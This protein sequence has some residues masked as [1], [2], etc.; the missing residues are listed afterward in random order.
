M[1]NQKSKKKYCPDCGGSQVNHRM[2]Y[3]SVFLGTMIEPWTNWMGKILPER[4]IEW[5]GPLVIK[6]LAF[7]RLGRITTK[8][9]KDDSGRTEVLWTEAIARGIDMR[10]FRLF[11][12]GHDIF[13]SKYKGQMRFFDVL[14]R[15][16]DYNPEGLGWMDNKNEM[17]KHFRKAGDIPVARGDIASTLSKGLKIFRSLDKP[18][19]TKPNIGSRSRHTTTHIGTEEEFRAAFKKAQQLSPWVMIEEELSGFVF[20]GTLI[21]KKLE[22][23]LRREP[24]YVEGDGI[25]AVRELIDRENENPLRQ[26]PIFHTLSLD[27]EAEKE[28]SHW[29]RTPDTVPRKGEAVTLGQ[30]TSRAV[31]GGIT[32]VTDMIHPDNRAMLERI[33][34][35]LDDPLI[36]VDFI[37][38]DIS[39]SWRDQPRSGVIECNSAPFIDLHHYPLVGKPRNIAARLWDIIYPESAV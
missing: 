23:V 4:S 24:A 3:T 8:P 37:M 34:D 39:V 1:Q 36:G 26:G 25:H 12:I 14:P 17:K 20:R 19:I 6:T 16:A 31:G 35:V 30:K 11:G 2:V 18:V 5:I 29:G 28:L 27:A 10:E 21:G 9:E 22:G 7:L 32:D 13:I 33:A 15:P 38:D